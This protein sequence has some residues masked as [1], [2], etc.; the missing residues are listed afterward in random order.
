MQD[1]RR[2]PAS[3]PRNPGAARD[4]PLHA[5]PLTEGQRDWELIVEAGHSF[6]PA[7]VYAQAWA[8][9]RWR[10]ENTDILDS[11]H[12]GLDA[13][14]RRPG[15]GGRDRRQ[16]PELSRRADPE[17]GGVREMAGLTP[18]RRGLY[19]T[20]SRSIPIFK[21]RQRALSRIFRRPESFFSAA[22]AAESPL[23]C[24]LDTRRSSPATIPTPTPA[25][26]RSSRDSS[27]SVYIHVDTTVLQHIEPEGR[28]RR[29]MRPAVAFP[30][31]GSATGERP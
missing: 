11:S 29:S 13:G 18:P 31:S 4:V 21:V 10:K 1:A 23:N 14:R 28:I 8:G 25:T 16:R 6:H 30:P 12:G 2:Y 15:G 5:S 17:R 3:G 9:H 22:R 27:S 26:F 24:A 19:M 7:P 20:R